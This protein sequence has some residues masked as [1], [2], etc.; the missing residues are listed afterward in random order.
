MDMSEREG[1]V[2]EGNSNRF[3]SDK[4]CSIFHYVTIL[5]LGVSLEHPAF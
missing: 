4:S 2:L 5:N 3:L 1:Q